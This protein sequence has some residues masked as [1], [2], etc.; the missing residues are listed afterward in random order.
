MDQNLEIK[1]GTSLS[2]AASMFI[3][4]QNLRDL[5]VQSFCST[6]FTLFRLSASLRSDLQTTSSC[7][8]HLNIP[9][10]PLVPLFSSSGDAVTGHEM[11]NINIIIRV[12]SQFCTNKYINK[13]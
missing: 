2:P 13:E 12:Y 10:S 11:I 1:A 4:N 8:Y 9:F 7:L 3:N 5:L 6:E